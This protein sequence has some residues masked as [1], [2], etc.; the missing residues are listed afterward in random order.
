MLDRG[1][2]GELQQVDLA[3]FPDKAVVKLGFVREVPQGPQHVWYA[4]PSQSP[5]VAAFAKQGISESEALK[6][7]MEVKA[8]EFV[9]SGAEIYRKQ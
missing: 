5:R 4:V 8:V 7:G 1:N 3:T 2:P 9:K 6:Q